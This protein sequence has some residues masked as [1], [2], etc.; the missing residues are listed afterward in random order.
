MFP[1]CCLQT[2]LLHFLAVGRL[3]KTPEGFDETKHAILTSY[4]IPALSDE[5]MTDVRTCFVRF[6]CRLDVVPFV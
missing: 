3:A 1:Y 6:V 2:D 5:K 4:A